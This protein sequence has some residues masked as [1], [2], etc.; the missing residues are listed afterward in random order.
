MPPAPH[1][2]RLEHE[3]RRFTLELWANAGAGSVLFYPGTMLSPSQ[4]RPLMRALHDAGLAVA[5]LHLEGH[6]VNP[7]KGGFTFASL[8][9]DGLHA[10]RWLHAAGAG[11][12]AVCGHSQGGI[13]AT[14]HAGRSRTL[15]AAFAICTIL[16]QMTEAI[17][18]TRFARFAGER[19][20]I[21][22]GIARL[23]RV[24]PWLPVT[25]NC[26]LSVRRVL[27]G[28][29]EIS[30]ARRGSR[31]SYPLGF[32]ASLFTTRVSP[33]LHCPF[34][35]YNA[36]DDALFT[37]ELA[38]AVFREIRAPEKSLVWLPSGGHM[39]P[40]APRQAAFIARDAAAVCAGLGMPLR[41]D[42]AGA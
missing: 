23:G 14:A 11:P 39:A 4:Y 34:R 31:L 25:V 42:A 15:T 8:L 1:F 13:L 3:G 16:P 2:Q 20:R 10:E 38:R 30:M 27:A 33:L 37:P 9:E 6:G 19:D 18:L 41:L 26:Y 40:M 17:T 12:V 29:G 5:G 7:H 35:L 24:L 21:E 28:H 32:L 22:S 36:K